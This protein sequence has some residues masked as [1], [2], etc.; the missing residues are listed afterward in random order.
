MF[1][2]MLSLKALN[3]RLRRMKEKKS[4]FIGLRVSVEELNR[5]KQRALLYCEGNMS[6]FI[7]YACLNYEIKEK[8]LEQKGK[9]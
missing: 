4:E 3:M 7:L 9:K 5:I 6:E 1:N 8:D 2:E